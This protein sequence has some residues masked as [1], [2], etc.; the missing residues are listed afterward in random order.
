MM[1]W[2]YSFVEDLGERYVV[3]QVHGMFARR[4]EVTMSK[5]TSVFQVCED[6]FQAGR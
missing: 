4:V 5:A 1:P 2:F 6:G 3:G